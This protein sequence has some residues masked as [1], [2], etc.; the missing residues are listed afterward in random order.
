[1]PENTQCAYCTFKVKELCHL[2]CSC[3]NFPYL[4]MTCCRDVLLGKKPNGELLGTLYLNFNLG[5]LK[6][7]IN[8]DPHKIGP[9]EVEHTFYQDNFYSTVIYTILER[10]VSK[11]SNVRY[12]DNFKNWVT[13]F[14]NLIEQNGVSHIKSLSPEEYLDHIVALNISYKARFYEPTL[15]KTNEPNITHA[16]ITDDSSDEDLETKPE[17]TDRGL[18]DLGLKETRLDFYRKKNKKDSASK[19]RQLSTTTSPVAVKKSKDRRPIVDTASGDRRR[20][21]KGKKL[22]QSERLKL[23]LWD[24]PAN[25]SSSKAP[26]ETVT[27]EQ[28]TKQ[29]DELVSKQENEYVNVIVDSSRNDEQP[30]SVSDTHFIIN[31]DVSYQEPAT[32]LSLVNMNVSDLVNLNFEDNTDLLSMLSQAFFNEPPEGEGIASTDAAV[33]FAD[34]E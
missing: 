24:P 23:N 26:E 17:V 19:K 20:L 4:C 7:N 18:I 31:E 15:K 21:G 34:A 16:E 9:N 14:Q 8:F 29:L 6:C 32:P 3:D 22:L 1:M 27:L 12:T 25:V 13:W 2:G 11:K 33:M 30:V 28:L 10:G 5:C